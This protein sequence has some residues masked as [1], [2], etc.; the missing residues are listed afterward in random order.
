M[1]LKPI[2]SSEDYGYLKVI[3]AS[4]GS[5]PLDR[6]SLQILRRKL[7]SAESLPPEVD[8]SPG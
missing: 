1:N 4:A 7:D 8:E 5:Y 3:A 2:L 6:E